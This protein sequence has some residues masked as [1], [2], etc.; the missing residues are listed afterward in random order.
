MSTKA[1]PF[2][3]R[4]CGLSDVGRVREAN[5]DAF[6]VSEQQGLFIVSDGMGG[7]RAGALASAMTV[8]TLPLQVSAE[9]LARN[10]GAP[11]AA[12]P[13]AAAG[14]VRAIGFINDT[15][16]DKTRD[17][18]EVKGLGATVVAG[19]YADDGVLVLA[20]LGDSRAYLLRRGFL[21]R[22]TADHT[23]AEMLFQAG[24]ISRR[25]LRRHPSRHVLTRHIG[26]EDCPAAD[27]VLLSTEPGDR[28]LFCTDGLTGMLNDREIGTILWETEEPE[29]A[30]RLLI[31]RANE[32]GG[33]DNITAVIVDVEKP[34]RGRGRRKRRVVVRRTVGRSL[35]IPQYEQRRE[36]DVFRSI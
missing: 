9:R 27:A 18:P 21:E 28:I 33:R 32:A 11:G 30:C 15:L 13:E 6:S 10:V 31:D 35:V 3:L 22:L 29:L 23:V 12:H 19:L 24:H 2:R 25:Q 5:E 26:K 1:E 34:R 7:A 14:V 20:H 4:A 8:Q 17:H 16:L 36:E